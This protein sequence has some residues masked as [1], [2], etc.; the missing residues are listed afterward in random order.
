MVPEGG[1]RPQETLLS[2]G[3]AGVWTQVPLVSTTS[4]LVREWPVLL[5]HALEAGG[6]Y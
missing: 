5:R 2:K 3:T 6:S 4:D 1:D